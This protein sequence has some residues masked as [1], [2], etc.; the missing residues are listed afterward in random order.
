MWVNEMTSFDNSVLHLI[1]RLIRARK[2]ELPATT[3]NISRHSPAVRPAKLRQAQFSDCQAVM[4]LKRRWNLIPESHDNW[5]RFW[6]LNPALSGCTAERPIG[7]VLESEGQLVGYLGSISARYHFADRTLAAV[8]SSGLVVEPAYRSMSFRLVA[9]FHR[10]DADLYLA[11]TAIPAVGQ[12]LRTFKSD[13]LPQAYYHAVLFWV[14]QPYPF[15]Q[16]VLRAL[17]LGPTFVRAGGLPGAFAVGFDKIL[18]RREPK[19]GSTSLNVSQ[20]RV[21]EIGDDFQALWI[22]KLKEKPRLLADRSPDVLRWH[23]SIPGDTGTTNVLCC[24]KARELVGYAVI[25][26]VP[27][28]MSG[29]RRTLIADMLAKQ[30]DPEVIRT[31]LV[32]AYEQAKQLESHVFEVI[33]FPHSIR[34]VCSEGNP[35]MREY[36]ATPFYYKAADPALHKIL[37]DGAAWYATPLDGDTTLMP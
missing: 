36:P 15:V 4:E 27:D 29:L 12:I 8:A 25:R 1:L 9:A 22:Q 10:Q 11:T 18:H 32:G 30:D 3:E 23:F 17:E 31:L 13:P 21:D 28:R 2:R 24:H 19:R 34:Q 14:L 33:G 37:S 16:A 35:Y 6:R 26:S 5:E 20:I 7:W